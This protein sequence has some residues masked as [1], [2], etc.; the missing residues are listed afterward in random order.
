M[1]L[2]REGEERG[3]MASS[4]ASRGVPGDFVTKRGSLAEIDHPIMFHTVPRDGAGLDEL[5]LAILKK[6]PRKHGLATSALPVL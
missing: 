4:R 6:G 3:A 5:Q 1:N 2:T